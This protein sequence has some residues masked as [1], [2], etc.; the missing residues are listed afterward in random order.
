MEAEQPKILKTDLGIKNNGFAYWVIFAYVKHLGILCIKTSNLH[1]IQNNWFYSSDVIGCFSSLP[2]SSR[3][4]IGWHFCSG[5]IRVHYPPTATI[6][7]SKFPDISLQ[8]L[9]SM[10]LPHICWYS[11]NTT[12]DITCKHYWQSVQIWCS[13]SFNLHYQG[14]MNSYSVCSLHKTITWL[15]ISA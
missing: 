1:F 11:L 10:S 5:P 15:L 6:P 4:S 9:F 7:D 12:K 13:V 8:M 14:I 3:S 2:A